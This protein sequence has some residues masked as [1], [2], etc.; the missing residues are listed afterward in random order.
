MRRYKTERRLLFTASRRD[1][2]KMARAARWCDEYSGKPS[3]RE[4]FTRIELAALKRR[5]GLEG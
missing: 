2:A 4:R 1:D 3:T 5:C